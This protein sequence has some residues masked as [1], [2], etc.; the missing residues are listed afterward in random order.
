MPT[1]ENDMSP[2]GHEASISYNPNNTYSEHPL[3]MPSH[4]LPQHRENTLDNIDLDI[5][6]NYQ[7]R[8]N[9]QQQNSYYNNYNNNKRDNYNLGTDP[10]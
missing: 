7:N 6:N 1:T 4:H 9:N 10:S 8:T 5:S 2:T 3:M